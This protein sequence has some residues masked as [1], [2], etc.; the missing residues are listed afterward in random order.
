MITF[1]VSRSLIASNRKAIVSAD[2]MIII[3]T[4]AYNLSLTL[5][6]RN[7][8]RTVPVREVRHDESG[9]SIWRNTFP[10]PRSQSRA[11]H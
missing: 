9:A 6:E 11:R 4:K 10:S 8:A 5:V 2:N 3:C 1:F 7:I